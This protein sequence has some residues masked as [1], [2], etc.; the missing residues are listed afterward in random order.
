M[1][2]TLWELDD[3]YEIKIVA[4]GRLEATQLVRMGVNRTLELA[5]CDAEAQENE[6]ISLWLLI[7]KR[8]RPE[9]TIPRPR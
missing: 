7:G 9:N 4:E 8:R 3:W 5:H 2:A 6:P 1:H